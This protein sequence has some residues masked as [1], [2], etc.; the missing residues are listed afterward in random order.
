MFYPGSLFR[1]HVPKNFK[2]TFG[3]DN[4]IDIY[5]SVVLCDD[6]DITT[7]KVL[8]IGDNVWRELQSLPMVLLNY[9]HPNE[10]YT[11]LLPPQGF[12]YRTHFF[13]P[14][15]CVLLDC[16][17]FSHHFEGLYLIILQMKDFGVENTW[18]QFIKNL[19][20][21][22]NDF[23]DASCLQ[24]MCISKDGDTLVLTNRKQTQVVLYNL[25]DNKVERTRIND[26]SWF[27]HVK[28]YVESLV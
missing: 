10:T 20:N 7:V 12:D 2:F 14:T 21:I 26:I 8:S 18:T 13:D 15:L 17:C 25:I 3:Y 9:T 28:D 22:H 11:M 27:I 19:E 24:P 4:S 1:H 16:L 6:E 5:K 23:V